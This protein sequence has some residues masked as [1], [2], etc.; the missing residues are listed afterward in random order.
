MIVYYVIIPIVYALCGIGWGFIR[1]KRFVDN[2]VE[3]YESERQRFLNHH[4][5]RGAD[6]PEF[7][8]FEWRRF[9]QASERLRE[10]PPKAHDYQGQI[11][12]DVVLWWL[13]L[14]FVVLSLLVSTAMRFIMTEY[15][16]I[17]QQ[18]IDRIKRD[19]KG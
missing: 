12:F 6:I 17:T 7:L 19:L 15:N 18:K 3:F 11:T 10:V 9:V 2:E 4:R 5:I 1:W 8:V 13:S 14:L 16:K